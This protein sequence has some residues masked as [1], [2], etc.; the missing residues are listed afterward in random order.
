MHAPSQ[1]SLPAA[2]VAPD[3]AIIAAGE[4]DQL[5]EVTPRDLHRQL[6]DCQRRLGTAAEKPDDFDRVLM[7]AHALNN[8]VAAAYLRVAAETAAVVPPSLIAI[9]KQILGD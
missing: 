6:R 3:A 7:L 5:Q 4:P 9:A 1:S 2:A 8:D